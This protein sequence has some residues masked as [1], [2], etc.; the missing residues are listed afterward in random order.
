MGRAPPSKMKQHNAAPAENV[1][2]TGP[3]TTCRRVLY[4][5]WYGNGFYKSQVEAVQDVHGKKY[6]RG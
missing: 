5:F 4:L 3:T 1:R 2:K 6:V